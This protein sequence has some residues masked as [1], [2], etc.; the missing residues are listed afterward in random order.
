MSA[1]EVAWYH[2]PSDR[3]DE[4]DAGVARS[5]AGLMPTLA[6]ACR[7]RCPTCR[8]DL[9]LAQY[10]RTGQPWCVRCTPDAALPPSRCACGE[11]ATVWRY[12]ATSATPYC[13][14][15]FERDQILR[16]GGL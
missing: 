13:V 6:D 7:P 9:Q 12:S 14:A 2:R 16:D 11:L 8:G 4:Y 15:C 5:E 1:E 3:L 10:G